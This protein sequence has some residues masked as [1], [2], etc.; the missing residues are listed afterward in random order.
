MRWDGLVP[1]ANS[2]SVARS[3]THLDGKLMGEK[4]LGGV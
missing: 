4:V 1:V 3:G 2:E